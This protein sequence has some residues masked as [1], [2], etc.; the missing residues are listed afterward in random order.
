MPLYPH[1]SMNRG[2]P[3][4]GSSGFLGWNLVVAI[5]PL[6]STFIIFFPPSGIYSESELASDSKALNSTRSDFLEWH[7]SVLFQG[8]LWYWHH[9]PV[10]FFIFSL[11]LLCCSL[12]WLSWEWPYFLYS[13]LF[14]LGMHFPYFR[15]EE[16]ADP[17]SLLLF[18]NLCSILTTYL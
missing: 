13:L 9:F 8:I 6:G 5:V 17:H 16:F 7:S 3:S 14:G 15:C 2:S 10:S 4:S 12:D 1:L 18:L 11:P